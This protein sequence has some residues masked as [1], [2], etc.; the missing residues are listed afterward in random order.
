M[1]ADAPA[2]S[3]DGPKD[4]KIDFKVNACGIQCPGPIMK[5]KKKIDE[6]ED[7]QVLQITA[8]EMGFLK[9]IPAWCDSTCNELL[10]ITTENGVHAA[11]IRKG[12]PDVCCALPDTS[13]LQKEK[14]IVVFSNDLDRA[15]AAFIIANGAAAMDNK[16]TLFFTFWGLNILR[17]EE[18]A[19]KKDAISAMFGAMMPK[20]PDA[21]KLSKMH[22]GGMGT[23]MMKMIMQQKNVNSLGELIRGAMEQGV[24]FVA[25]SMTMDIMGI[26]HEELI[27]G[28]EIGGVADYLNT[29]DRANMSMFI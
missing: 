13:F 21:L 18:A 25:C 3:A 23:K 20:G 12:R 15:L 4:N 29:A 14:T 28:V 1:T 27:D 7:G 22:M 11:V 9:D 8:T 5:L 19:V 2:P 10:S 6:I 26:Q 17:K 24:R 16:V